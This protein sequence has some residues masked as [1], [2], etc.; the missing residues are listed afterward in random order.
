VSDGSTTSVVANWSTTN[1]FTWTPS[2][3]NANYRVSAWVRSAGSAADQAEAAADKGFVIEAPP[4]TTTPAPAPPTSVA[5][6]AVTLTSSK[7]SPQPAGTPIVFT[8]QAAGGVGPHQY[9]WWTFENQTWTLLADWNN[10]STLTWWRKTAD[11][12]YQVQVRVR[13]ACPSC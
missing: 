3:A 5:P 4:I 11:P 10:Y 13:S 6:V 2:A 12:K 8:A 1:A 7:P 9:Q